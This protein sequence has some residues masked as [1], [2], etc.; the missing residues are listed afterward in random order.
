ME[1]SR[2]G[3][4]AMRRIEAGSGWGSSRSLERF[5]VLPKVM[6]DVGKE[7]DFTL[8]FLVGSNLDGR[9]TTYSTTR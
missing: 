1:S 6:L 2:K 8:V 3:L 9:L 4:N 5:R 7:S